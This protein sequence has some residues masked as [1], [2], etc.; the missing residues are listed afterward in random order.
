MMFTFEFTPEAMADLLAIRKYDQSLIVAAIESQ[1]AHQPTEPTRNRKR[2]RPNRLAEW[3]L[4]IGDYLVFYLVIE[5]S[6]V[7]LRAS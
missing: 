1:L 7:I 2:L 3:E 4:R 6:V 5:E